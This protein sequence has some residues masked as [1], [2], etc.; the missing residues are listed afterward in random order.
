VLGGDAVEV[1][2]EVLRRS[3]HIR[4]ASAQ[5]NES[6][7]N[8]IWVNFLM[9]VHSMVLVS[10]GHHKNQQKPK[11]HWQH[12]VKDFLEKSC[13]LSDESS[14]LLAMADLSIPNPAPSFFLTPLFIPRSRAEE[15]LIFIR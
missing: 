3:Y 2:L 14:C 5:P 1:Q 6:K 9:M 8:I 4:E 11:V 13:L 15:H 10:E 7:P 12:H